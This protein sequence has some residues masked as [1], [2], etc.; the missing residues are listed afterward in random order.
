MRDNKQA[1]RGFTL[2]ELMIVVAIIGILAS[3]AVPAYQAFT[4]RAK[5]TEGFVLASDA[6]MAV[7][8]TLGIPPQR[9]RGRVCGDRGRAI[10][11]IWLQF[12]AH[13]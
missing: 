2:I 8:G 7:A 1:E 13:R 11:L 5:L 6:R 12:H 10:R 9:P 3:I 4:I